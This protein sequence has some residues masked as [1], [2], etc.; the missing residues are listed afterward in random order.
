MLVLCFHFPMSLCQGSPFIH[1]FP[2]FKSEMTDYHNRDNNNYNYRIAAAAAATILT[3]AII[4]ATSSIMMMMTTPSA[5]TTTT[6]AETTMPAS[7]SGVELSP[8]PIYEERSPPG[9]ITPI[10]ETH[11]VITF[12]GNGV[13]TLPNTTQTINTAHNGTALISFTTPSGYAK[14]TIRTENG[15]TA[16]ATVYEI[17]QLNPAAPGEGKGIVIAVFHTN[18]TGRLA[19]LN[20]L[21][22]TGIDEFYANQTGLLTLWEWQSGIPLPPATTMEESPSSPTKQQ[23]AS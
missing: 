12:S 13:L 16:T 11:G 7:S 4:I 18:S 22:L 3:V 20:G 23:P 6:E 2:A 17:V 19:P 10:N 5:A 21:I 9:I 1:S 15:E 8:Q 14:E